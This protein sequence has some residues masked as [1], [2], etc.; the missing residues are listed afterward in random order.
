MVEEEYRFY[1]GIDW[2]TE[3]HQ[4]CVLDRTRKLV[5]ERSFAHAG[6]ALARSMAE[7]AGGR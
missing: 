2:A 6:D 1:V 7:R 4:A 3:A 5:S